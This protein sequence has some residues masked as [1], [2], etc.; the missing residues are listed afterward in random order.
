M[1]GVAQWIEH[2]PANQRVA[3]SITSQGTSLGCCQA[4]SRGCA[5]G[6]HTLM[7]LSLSFSFPSLSLKIN[8]ILKK[9]FFSLKRTLKSRKREGAAAQGRG[10]EY[11]NSFKVR[12]DIQGQKAC[13]TPDN[14]YSS[15]SRIQLTYNCSNQPNLVN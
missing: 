11:P 14:I 7:F 5:R 1:A 4:P 8:K 12:L 13:P 9:K 3:G 6:K 2:W 15:S 10:Q